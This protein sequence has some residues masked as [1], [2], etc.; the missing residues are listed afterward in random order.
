[1]VVDEPESSNQS[2]APAQPS[3]QSFEI[4]Q[5]PAGYELTGIIVHLGSSTHSGH[6]V[7]Y[8]KKNGQWVLYNDR[9]VT[10]SEKP[11]I[12]GCYLSIWTRI[13]K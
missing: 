4:D 11:P 12:G 3:K 5:K 2:S 7:A 13:A 10:V 9:K 1:M 8:I 6:Y